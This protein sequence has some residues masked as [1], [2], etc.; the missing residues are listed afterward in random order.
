MDTH[1][2]TPVHTPALDGY[3]T[4]DGHYL[5]RSAGRSW[6]V[7]ASTDMAPDDLIATMVP[8]LEAAIRETT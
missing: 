1:N 3:I 6:D 2:L 8:T 4:A 5:A 7:Y